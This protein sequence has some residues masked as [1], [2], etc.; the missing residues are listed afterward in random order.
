VRLQIIG[1]ECQVD[2][3]KKNF[4]ENFGC[5]IEQESTTTKRKTKKKKKLGVVVGAGDL[6]THQQW[7][8]IRPQQL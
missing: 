3:H 2:R 8:E 1:I 7:L 5:F 6:D 4:E